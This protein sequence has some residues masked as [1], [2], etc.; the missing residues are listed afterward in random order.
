MKKSKKITAL[1]LSSM[2]TIGALTT[3]PYNVSATS[4]DFDSN[5]TVY[6]AKPSDK[7][8]ENLNLDFWGDNIKV[9]AWNESGN[10]NGDWP[11]DA[12]THV[13][14]NIYSYTWYGVFPTGIIIN[15]GDNGV[16][17]QNIDGGYTVPK[18]DATQARKNPELEYGRVYKATGES[19]EDSNGNT[20]IVVAVDGEST[21]N[22][23]GYRL[24]DDDTVTILGYD[25]SNA[26]ITIP[27]EI[28]GFPV[29]EI[30][31]GAFNNCETLENI[32]VSDNNKA[33]CS[34]DGVLFNKDKTKL[35]CYPDKKAGAKYSIPDS[36]VTIGKCAFAGN[37]SIESIE[38]PDSVQEICDRAF[39]SCTKLKDINIP[40]SVVLIE[41]GDG[42]GIFSYC[43]SLTNITIPNSITTIPWYTFSYCTSL[44]NVTIP[45]SVNTIDCGAF[46]GCIGLKNITIP[47]SVTEINSNAFA[48]CSG[49]ESINIPDGVTSLD[50]SVFD[51]CTTLKDIKIPDNVTLIGN[52][53]FAN[54]KSLTSIVIP[55]SVE[56]LAYGAF[57][58]CDN[59]KSATILNS[60]TDIRDGA[61]DD[62]QD[63]T[64]YGYVGSTAETY[65]KE[66][67]IPFVDI[68]SKVLTSKVNNISVKG[69]FDDGVTL[70]VEEATVKNA[71]KAY[72]ITLKDEN[73]NTIQP[74][75]KITVSIPS[76]NANC[77][78][79]WIKEDG[80]KVDMNATYNNG[81]YE[82]T[83]DH[84]SV[85]ALI[86]DT[87]EPSQE[88]SGEQNNSSS[89]SSGE[90]SNN[91][92]E[93]SNNTNSSKTTSE[94]GKNAVN[95]GDNNTTAI[96]A[97][98]AAGALAAII[99][100]RKKKA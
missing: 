68:N 15:N 48:D 24:E 93:P 70:N 92:S 37:K 63:L 98:F 49:L 6:F 36:V 52:Y 31:S 14:G 22:D 97:I 91:P 90:Q 67:N 12:A 30:S 81:N 32:N 85:Y 87:T 99:L 88:S 34:V 75:G 94:T 16:Q 17:T 89:E 40:D 5:N 43:T 18:S 2:L 47:D 53:T 26:N 20:N 23:F 69:T 80:T 72:N 86:A 61:F 74:N 76:D 35:I 29:K 95:T 7:L 1:V 57:A 39:L 11:G 64:I 19:V 60:D 25:G 41:D 42:A 84:L 4:I 10:L 65:A 13:E 38:I 78:V 45:N 28:Y 54:C 51:G 46:S 27:D 62:S 44:T 50:N 66:N 21:Y 33:C 56:W 100:M 59:L 82:F 9:H 58:G 96:A 55:N 83:T 73:G 77:K 79:Y 71:V 8:L 3:L